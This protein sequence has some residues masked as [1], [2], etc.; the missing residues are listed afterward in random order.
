[1]KKFYLF[2][3]LVFSLV[4]ADAVLNEKN[5][6]HT[7]GVLRVELATTYNDLKQSTEQ[8]KKHSELQHQRMI[9]TMQKS[10]Q[11]ALMLYSQKSN[12]TFNMTYVCHEASEMYHEFTAHMLPY[13]RI[14]QRLDAEII[15]YSRLIHTLQSLP[16]SLVK[17]KH[18]PAQEHKD[19]PQ[20]AENHIDTLRMKIDSVG[21]KKHLFF[22]SDKG[23]EDRAECIGFARIIL[24]RYKDMREDISR[25]SEHY[26]HLKL[27]LKEVYDYAQKRYKDIQQ[28]IFVNGDES[29]F[30]ILSHLNRSIRQ[31]KR[32]LIDKY[33]NKNY[34]Y[35]HIKSEWRGS[36][37]FGLVL[38]VVI[39]IT[40]SFILSNIIVRLLMRKIKRLRENKEMQL[41]AD[42]FIIAGSSLL[43]AIAMI[44]V[45]TIMHHNFIVMAS[46]LLVSYAW[47]ITTILVSLLIRLNGEQIKGALRM[48]M[49][50]MT[51]GF[52]VIIFRI[53]FIPNTL[54]NLVFPPIMLLF[55]I[56]QYVVL[57]H[58]GKDATMNDKIYSWISL[59]LMCIATVISWAGYVLMGVQIFI[60]WLILLMLILTVTCVYDF[61][62]TQ[63]QKYLQ[64]KLNLKKAPERGWLK[65]NG[66]E[67][68]STWFYDLLLM[69]VLPICIIL[70]IIMSFY[71]AAQV[72]DLTDIC[73]RVFF[74]PFVDIPGVCRLSVAKITMLANLYFVFNYVC[75][76]VKS[77]YRTLRIRHIKSKN[78]GAA[79]A[80]NQANFTLFYNITAIVVWGSYFIMIL[81][82]LQVPKNGISIVTAGLATGLGFAMKDLLENFFYGISLMTGRLRVGDWIE[83]DGI[84]GK[85]DSITYQS[86]SIVTDDGS[87]IAFLNSALFTKN[88]ENL[89][90]NH[91]YVK[92]KVKIGVSYGSDIDKIRKILVDNISAMA[93]K[94]KNGRDVM[95]TKKGV[96]VLLAEFGDSSIELVVVYWTLVSE[97]IGFDCKVNEMIYNT[98]NKHHIEIPFPQ[99]DLHIISH[100]QQAPKNKKGKGVASE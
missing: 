96:S 94:N 41:K 22:L 14:M 86:T 85:V 82:V 53:I 9:N 84:R 33:E 15:R 43:F 54:V 5:L 58:A 42:C 77:T 98:L 63:E 83:C 68:A 18:K 57:R 69:V 1:M 26:E 46:Q 50:I 35:N 32:D 8:I 11:V 23:K 30:S 2:F 74:T 65:R 36:I 64:K 20:Q 93:Y 25:D 10:N 49:P 81:V 6:E 91:S 99:R 39:Y 87:V 31:T 95:D 59:F 72:F 34:E 56:W 78:K 61:L 44:I 76:V 47:L 67:I 27:H 17:D 80:T 92:S 16:P 88:F 90:R 62:T 89:T 7:L 38:F 55:T 97:K 28:S 71:M 19:Q 3:A 51:L 73:M 4:H 52:I 45:K 29:Y 21:M 12:Y 48:F 100:P 66:N 40:V 70:S 79:V 37:V 13:G 75:Y 60:W 24:K